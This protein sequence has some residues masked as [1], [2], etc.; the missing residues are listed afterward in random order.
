VAGLVLAAVAAP[1]ARALLYGIGPPDLVAPAAGIA[2]LL[3]VVVAA[4]WKPARAAARTDP[5][6]ALRA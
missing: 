3:V 6:V 1:A 4:S 5:A 2:V